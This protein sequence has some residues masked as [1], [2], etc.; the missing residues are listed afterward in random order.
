M[1]K[2][3]GKGRIPHSAALCTNPQPEPL[4]CKKVFKPFDLT[5]A[6]FS[7]NKPRMRADFD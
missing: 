2:R 5:D 1:T 6:G 7:L 3:N 4:F